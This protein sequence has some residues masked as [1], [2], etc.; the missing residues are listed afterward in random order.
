MGQPDETRIDDL[1]TSVERMAQKM[2][3]MVTIGSQRAPDPVR[4]KEA[5]ASGNDNSVADLEAQVDDLSNL[6]LP[7]KELMEKQLR[8]KTLREQ[9]RDRM[10]EDERLYSEK[11]LKEIKKLY[12]QG[13]WESDE[14]PSRN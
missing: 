11:E 14:K 13:E 12:H 3:Q 2:R 7:Y 8:L 6:I 10:L 5:G 1:S 9:A 4:V